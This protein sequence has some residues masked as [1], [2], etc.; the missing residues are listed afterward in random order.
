MTE[1]ILLRPAHEIAAAVR[2]RTVSAR[3]VAEAALARIAATN[4][5][6]NAFTAV[7]GGRAPA[8]ADAVD[9]GIPAGKGPPPY[10]WGTG[11]MGQDGGGGG[12]GKGTAA[13]FPPACS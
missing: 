4:G 10:G 5:R 13:A 7:A 6:L 9:A 11:H 2:A 3:E 8:Q 12:E 1:P